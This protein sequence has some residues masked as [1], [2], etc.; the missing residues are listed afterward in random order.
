M[1]MRRK[2]VYRP[3]HIILGAKTM[4]SFFSS[5]LSRAESECFGLQSTHWNP[6]ILSSVIGSFHREMPKASDRMTCVMLFSWV[7]FGW[8]CD[9]SII[10]TFGQPRDVTVE[11]AAFVAH[12]GQCPTDFA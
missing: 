10:G 6:S 2:K 1:D 7:R 8:P 9:A 3:V 4:S 11:D 12:L 5:A